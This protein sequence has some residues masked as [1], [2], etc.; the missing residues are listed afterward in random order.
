MTDH[1][2]RPNTAQRRAGEAFEV[3]NAYYI[4]LGAGGAWAADSIDTGCLRFGWPRQV[5]GDLRTGRWDEV[6]NQIRSE[7]SDRGAATRDLIALRSIVASSLVDIWI[8]FASGRLWWGRVADDP[9]DEDQQSKFRRMQSG[10]SD[11]DLNGRQLLV[12]QL[13]GKL[14]QLQGFRATVCTVADV[15]LLKRV[16]GGTRSPISV[17]LQGHREAA[18]RAAAS[19]IEALHWR[20]YELLVDMVFR[21]TG[22]RRDSVL[23][24]QEDGY[25]LMLREPI[26][27]DLNVVQIKSQAGL[28]E[29]EAVAAKFPAGFCRRLFF[30]V[31]SPSPDLARAKRGSL[32]AHVEVVP[33]ARLAELAI[34]AGLSRWLE[35]KMA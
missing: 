23:G 28:A 6:E 9:V 22:W 32:P 31:H 4:K 16:L 12:S 19:A 33:P 26:T 8:T 14:Q 21:A 34:D 10:W 20:D 29:V 3:R 30:V 15:D 25:D 27:H 35:A 2:D 11:R 5:I 17:K 13:P 24:E 1:A 7:I 18:A